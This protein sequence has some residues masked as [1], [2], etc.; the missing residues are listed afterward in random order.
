MIGIAVVAMLALAPEFA[1]AR[2]V[3]RYDDHV[4][5]TAWV[6]DDD[7][8]AELTRLSQQIWTERPGPGVVEALVSPWGLERLA[9]S[10]I[11]YEVRTTDVQQAV[12]LERE[13]LRTRTDP[14]AG[15]DAWFSDFRDLAEIQDKVAQWAA[16]DPDRVTVET[17]GES[18]EGR[19]I[20]A[21]RLGSDAPDAPAVLFTGTMH[22]REWLA[23]MSTMCVADTFVTSTDPVVLDLLDRIAVLIVPMINPD[24]Y[25]ISWTSDRYWRKNARDGYGV[26]LN[27]NWDYEWAVVGSSSDP[28]AE[29]YHGTSPFSEP[30]T[31]TLRDFITGEPNLVAH[32]D[33]HSYSQLILRPWG[34]TYDSPP[35]EPV[36]AMLG[37][38]MS[39]AMWAATSTDY[40]SIHAAELYPA[41]GAIDDWVY[42]ERGMMGFTIE[43]RGDDFVVPPS[44][45]D[46]ACRENV[47][48]ALA[49]AAWA[50]QDA[51]PSDDG[52]G[53]DDGGETGHDP[54]PSDDDGASNDDSSDDDDAPGDDD[55]GTDGADDDGANDDDAGDDDDVPDA[56]P[57]GFGLGAGEPTACGCRSSDTSNAAAWLVTGLCLL[58][59]RRAARGGAHRALASHTTLSTR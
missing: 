5:V 36:L 52:G 39:D 13:R 35:D 24:G 3:V 22:A 26:D 11:A 10:S 45:I 42:G 20:A 54:P 59:R 53:E 12:D 7:D 1:T 25:V 9:A 40:P 46:P 6:D 57:P 43:M 28:Y 34:F 55:A 49:L 19:P 8:L 14:T 30:E 21:L 33:F 32:I 18:L 15:G 27:R 48:A 58:R 44:Q 50:A 23:T 4:V 41:A 38:D 37:Q 47:A 16:D 17:I 56:L 51:P 29:D 31:A 2:P